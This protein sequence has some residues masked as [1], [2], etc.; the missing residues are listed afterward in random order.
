MEEVG[1]DYRRSLYAAT[2]R[3]NELMPPSCSHLFRLPTTGLRFFTVYGPWGRP[4]AAEFKFT[5]SILAGTPIDVF[6]H[7][8]MQRAFTYIG[9]IVEGPARTVDCPQAA[10]AHFNRSVPNP[11]RSAALYSLFNICN[12][13]PVPLTDFIGAIE[14]AVG[15]KAR[16]NLLPMQPGDVV[17]TYADVSALTEWTGFKPETALSVGVA[18]FVAWYRDCYK[19]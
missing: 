6:N 10:D 3:A 8:R 11:S 4:G 12:Q 2:K 14:V 16:L 17:A 1:A 13:G 15:R 19:S 9:D 7:D 5:R 18:R